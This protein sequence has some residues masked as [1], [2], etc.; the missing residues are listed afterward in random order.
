MRQLPHPQ[1]DGVVERPSVSC[2]DCVSISRPFD[3]TQSTLLSL[4]THKGIGF[5]GEFDE[6][7]HTKS[8]KLCLSNKHFGC[9]LLSTYFRR[10]AVLHVS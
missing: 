4:P 5:L 7:K 9:F 3:R 10:T 6:N 8:K 1:G 2:K